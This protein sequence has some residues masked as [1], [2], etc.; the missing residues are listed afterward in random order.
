MCKKVL[1]VSAK[2]GVGKTTVAVSLARALSKNHLVGLIDIDLDKPSCHLAFNIGEK[3]EARVIGE[4]FHPI[5]VEGIEFISNAL[6]FGRDATA[7]WTK[8]DKAEASLQLLELTKFDASYIIIDSPPGITE[9][10]QLV[11]KHGRID[12]GII[13]STPSPMDLDGAKRTLFVAR[14]FGLPLLGVVLNRCHSE[15]VGKKIWWDIGYPHRIR[16]SLPVLGTI[17]ENP[18][19]AQTMRIKGMEPI[20]ERVVQALKKPVIIKRDTLGR[21]LKRA[22]TKFMVRR[23]L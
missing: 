4:R 2:G 3:A 9:S 12:G 21:K 17:Q 13:I 14:E 5:K 11:L 10:L 19:I 7:I 6:L 16:V 8:R 23:L 18:K 15:P 22:A 20:A 1:T